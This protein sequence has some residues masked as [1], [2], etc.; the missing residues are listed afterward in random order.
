MSQDGRQQENPFYLQYGQGAFAF[1]TP[2][3]N[4]ARAEVAP[5]LGRWYRLTG[6]RAGGEI[7]LYLDGQRV[8][9]A[10]AGPAIVSTGGL[11]VGRA[12]FGGQNTDFWRG[13]IDDVSVVGRALTDAEV[14]GR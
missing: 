7:R 9:T 6:V 12:K 5:E 14:A 3:G 4:R 8:A 1:S 11:A 13:A 2:G 10:P